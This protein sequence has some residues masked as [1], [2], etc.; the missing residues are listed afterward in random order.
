MARL[1]AK[2]TKLIEVAVD[3]IFEAM[4]AQALGPEAVGKRLFIGH[5]PFLSLPGIFEHASQLEGA[6]V[7]K[8]TLD[9]L[10]KIAGN[11]F[12]AA[13]FRAKARVIN[14]LESYLKSIQAT[15]ENTDISKVVSQQ[16][17][18]VWD[19]VTSDVVRIVD[20]EASKFKSI[21]I[22]DGIVRANAQIG[23]NDPTVYFIVVRDQSLCDECRKIHM[24]PDGIIPRAWKLSQ[25]SHQYHV[26]G[27]FFPSLGGLHP[28]C[29][30]TMG[31]ILPGWGFDQSGMLTWKGD[32][33]D[34]YAMQQHIDTM[35][36]GNSP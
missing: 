9:N 26:R 15:E 34:E 5:D 19:N 12:E 30:C 17:S 14:A 23:I 18:S 1:S 16:L 32:G 21:G 25:V 13:K 8:E 24:R 31:T 7:D 2:T 22:L 33:W 4:K 6:P 36:G 35:T 20:T 3:H 29:R 11:Y 27:D 28:H 10:V